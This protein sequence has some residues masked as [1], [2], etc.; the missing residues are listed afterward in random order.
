MHQA[1]FRASYNEAIEELEFQELFEAVHERY[2]AQDNHL[3]LL[4][5]D[6]SARRVLPERN[7]SNKSPSPPVSLRYGY[8]LLLMTIA[9]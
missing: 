6:R 2:N 4:R 3:H 7:P 8:P 9:N 1:E 5:A